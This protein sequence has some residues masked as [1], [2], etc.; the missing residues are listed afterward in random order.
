M[1][2]SFSPGGSTSF[3]LV[4]RASRDPITFGSIQRIHMLIRHHKDAAHLRVYGLYALCNV[5]QQ[6]RRNADVIVFCPRFT[7]SLVS[8]LRLAYNSRPT[9]LAMTSNSSTSA[10]YRLGFDGLLPIAQCA[11]RVVVHLDDEPVGPLP[12]QPP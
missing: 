4:P 11:G 12:P 6:P 3:R 7:C 8:M 2:L 1:P 10:A 9:A 5:R